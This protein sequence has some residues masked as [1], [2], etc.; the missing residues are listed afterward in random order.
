MEQSFAEQYREDS[1]KKKA[2]EIKRR[3][4][5]K[6][7]VCEQQLPDKLTVH[8]GYYNSLMKIWEVEDQT[9]W[10]V[11][12]PCHRKIQ[13]EHTKLKFLLGLC[14]PNF[15]SQLAEFLIQQGSPYLKWCGY[16]TP[17]QVRQFLAAIK[18]PAEEIDYRLY[19]VVIL[20]ATELG[21]SRAHEFAAHAEKTFPGLQILVQGVSGETDCEFSL[22]GPDDDVK[23]DLEQWLSFHRGKYC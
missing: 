1:W 5:Y 12:W 23:H 19:E 17:E 9:L 4:D 14:N 20:E 21:P 8:H 22:S 10:C 13:R 11:C 3:E 2:E 15:Y 18:L 7:E 16:R 6:C